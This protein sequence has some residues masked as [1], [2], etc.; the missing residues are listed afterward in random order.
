MRRSNGVAL[1]VMILPLAV[2]GT[3]GSCP[4]SRR[5]SDSS[6]ESVGLTSFGNGCTVV[7]SRPMKAV[8]LIVLAVPALFCAGCASGPVLPKVEFVRPP[9]DRA[10]IYVYRTGLYRGPIDIW[11]D[12]GFAGQMLPDTFTLLQVRP[13]P[14]LVGSEGGN[15]L[16]LHVIGGEVVFLEQD[17]SVV[18]S[19]VCAIAADKI[20]TGC[21]TS[22]LARVSAADGRAAVRERRLI[23][24]KPPPLP[25]ADEST[26]PA[27]PRLTGRPT[28]ASRQR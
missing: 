16:P 28:P 11:L 22:E 6:Q 24:D 8:L 15:D 27:E 21:V 7:S 18:H 14:H 12:S 5:A 13:G 26:V 20:R 19:W 23:L 3:S 25:P 10:Y 9:P 17:I 4:G 1:F 2:P